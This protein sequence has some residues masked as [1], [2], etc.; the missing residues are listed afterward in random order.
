M[1]PASRT[2]SPSPIR[3]NPAP[4]GSL[5]RGGLLR[6]STTSASG[7]YFTV[8]CTLAPGACLLALVRPSWAMR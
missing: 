1:P 7:S 6:T 8:T 4:P 2:R 5:A 3:P